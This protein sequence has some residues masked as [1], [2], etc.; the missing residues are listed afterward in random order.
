MQQS[1]VAVALYVSHILSPSDT[2]GSPESRLVPLIQMRSPPAVEPLAISSSVNV[3]E[4]VAAS[5]RYPPASVS[6]P[7]SSPPLNASVA[8]RTVVWV[9]TSTN[10]EAVGPVTHWSERCT[11]AMTVQSARSVEPSLALRVTFM[12][13]G[14]EMKPLPWMVSS[15][16]PAADPAALPLAAG[17]QIAVMPRTP[18]RT[19]E[20]LCDA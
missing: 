7:T 4:S 1:C 14:S 17:P 13:D 9:S 19:T 11:L 15:T 16:P 6:L 3:I 20:P 2:V 18:L 5:S 10:G 12:K 8:T